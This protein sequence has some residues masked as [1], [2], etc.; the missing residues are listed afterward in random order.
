LRASR[1]AD[2]EADEN[3][4]FE[5]LCSGLVPPCNIR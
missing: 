1:I 2:V 4:G 3:D 5:M